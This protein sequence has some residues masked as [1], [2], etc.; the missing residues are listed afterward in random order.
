MINA[1]VIGLGWWGR[2]FVTA[3]KDS[4]RIQITGLA[5]RSPEKHRDFADEQGLPLYESY[6][7]VLRDPA[8]D[9][10]LLCTPNSQHE[11]QVLEAL[12]A[13]KQVFC[14]KPLALSRESAERIVEAAAAKGR[15]LG[16]GHE[17]R[18][19]PPMEEI[20]RLVEAGDLGTVLHV[21]ANWSHDLLVGL[22]PASWRVSPA[23][24]PSIG[25]TGMGVHMTDLM[26]A[27]L[28]PV[29]AVS[30]S[31]ADR[32]LGFP[33]GD[34]T[35]LQL[36][37]RSGAT[38]F[39]ATMVATPYYCRYGVFGDRIWAEARD[40]GHPQHGGETYLTV[41]GKDGGQKNRRFEARDSARA[42]LEEWAAAVEGEG[43]Y[44]FSA[45][46]L[47]GNIAVLEAIGRSAEDGGAWVE[48]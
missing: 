27:M 7:A 8:V 24:G 11:S 30:A 41:C 45:E 42:N 48:L 16:I 1:V 32:V 26:I 20:V 3:L 22:D 29:E 28:G 37:F 23:E 31:R 34:V 9:A 2:H 33:T 12:E 19:E 5:A 17:R 15:V 18:F 10:V 21:E 14:E 40:S 6:Q 39:L 25:M 46:E 4:A 43:R 44:R 47:I 38:G 36:R 13:G 35:A